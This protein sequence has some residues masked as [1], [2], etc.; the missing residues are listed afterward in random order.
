MAYES[1]SFRRIFPLS[2]SLSLSL[3]FT[4]A[5]PSLAL[6][7]SP[8]SNAPAQTMIEAAYEN[9]LSFWI[10][11]QD[12]IS[13]LESHA[14]DAQSASV[15]APIVPSINPPSFKPAPQNNTISG[16]S[17]LLASVAS[18]WKA[19]SD[20]VTT[21]FQKIAEQFAPV[22]VQPSV[23]PPPPSRSATASTDSTQ[24]T[25]SAQATVDS[26][27]ITQPV[28]SEPVE[29]VTE[30]IVQ[31][32]AASSDN[33]VTKTELSDKLTDLSNVFARTV[34]GSTYP[35][36][37]TSYASGG[38]MSTV[39]L[40]GRIDNLSGTSLS[41]ITVSGVSGLTDADIPDGITASNYLT[42]TGGTLSGDLTLTGN[43]TVSGA[44]T[45][46]GAIT[47]P[48]LTATSTTADSSFIRLTA[49]NATTT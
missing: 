27:Y 4:L 11:V 16:A 41:S 5:A 36:P 25:R 8:A 14:S 37:A 21:R 46:S 31:T 1:G 32:N 12:L 26:Q 17:G 47:I 24:S 30:R 42:L 29:R 6:A 44:P 43:L 45:L 39:A 48:Y 20:W 34:Y 18:A 38:I 15:V 7:A 22:A 28:Y 9:T 19:V 33:Y 10:P 49:T 35:A 23:S 40:M 3:C 13:G 2:L